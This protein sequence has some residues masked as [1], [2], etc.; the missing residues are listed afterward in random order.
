MK[1]VLS[2]L[3]ASIMWIITGKYNPLPAQE[4]TVMMPVTVSDLCQLAA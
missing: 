2:I 4:A 3:A 1:Y